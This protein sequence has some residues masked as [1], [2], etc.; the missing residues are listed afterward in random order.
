M[1]AVM[2]AEI[3]TRNQAKTGALI[4]HRSG[5]IDQRTGR[6]NSPSERPPAQSQE[7]MFSTAQSGN[8]GFI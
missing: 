6:L 7:L 2:L 4:L 3:T 1:H 8:G 5:Q